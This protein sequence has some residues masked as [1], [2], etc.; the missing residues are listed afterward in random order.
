MSDLAVPVPVPVPAPADKGTSVVKDLMTPTT[1]RA[2]IVTLLGVLGVIAGALGHQFNIPTVPDAALTAISG[3]IVIAVQAVRNVVHG[4]VT[5]V[6]LQNDA[7]FLK[8][9]LPQIQADVASLQPL[10]TQISEIKLT[11]DSAVNVANEAKGQ[12]VDLQAQLDALPAAQK[13]QVEAALRGLLASA[14]VA[15]VPTTVPIT[16]AV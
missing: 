1:V 10:V 16:P 4:A 8:D 3:L 2:D 12:A 15:P 9:A 14:V 13:D 7:V 5:K 11:A 6:A